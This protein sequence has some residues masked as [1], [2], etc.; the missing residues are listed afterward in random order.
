MEIETIAHIM[1]SM[2]KGFEKKGVESRA[3]TEFRKGLAEQLGCEEAAAA[4]QGED[5]LVP[6]VF[7]LT[8]GAME[9]I[10]FISNYDNKS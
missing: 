5:E 4:A 1:I 2:M 8:G 10:G 6:L 7:N 9:N 3:K